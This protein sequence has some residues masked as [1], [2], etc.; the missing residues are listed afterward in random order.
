MSRT[1]Y[2]L[3]GLFLVA[4]LGVF[5]ISIGCEAPQPRPFPPPAVP[6]CDED[7]DIETE[8]EG[9]GMGVSIKGKTKIKIKRRTPPTTQPIP[10]LPELEEE[11]MDNSLSLDFPDSGQGDLSPT[12]TTPSRETTEEDVSFGISIPL[13]TDD[14]EET[15]MDPSFMKA[16]MEGF[17]TEPMAGKETSECGLPV[18]RS[19]MIAPGSWEP[20]IYIWELPTT[21]QLYGVLITGTPEQIGITLK[22]DLGFT[23]MSGP[24]VAWFWRQLPPDEQSQLETLG[25][26]YDNG[27]D[28]EEPCDGKLIF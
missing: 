4:C 1:N 18:V 13:I 2:I 15:W 6:G 26:H 17:Q 27:G 16:R 21:T 28:R 7:I 12:T 20:G 9:Q 24:A 3:F 19:A 11:E 22:E 25:V 23:E 5:T 14:E 10:D 8:G